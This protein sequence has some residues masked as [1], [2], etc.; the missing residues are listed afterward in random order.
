MSSLLTPDFGLLFWMVISFI[1]VLALL[2]KFGFPV[3]VKSVNKRSDYIR[4]SLE[5][6]DQANRKLDSIK[7]EAGT[8]TDQA[9]QKQAEIIKNA[10]AEGGDIVR[11]AQERASAESEKQLLAARERIDSQKKKA[12]EEINAQVAEMAIEIAEKVL[13]RQ[14]DDPA[15]QQELILKMLE[16]AESLDNGMNKQNS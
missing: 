5:V 16:E 14:L 3:I 10:M 1:I 13:R 4:N 12:L 8:I 7:L 11:S 6:A 9:R 2:A 15:R